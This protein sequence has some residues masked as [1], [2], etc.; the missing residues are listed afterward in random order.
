MSEEKP[1]VK[2]APRKKKEDTPKAAEAPK[3]VSG[4]PATHE[5]KHDA[6]PAEAKAEVKPE[7]KPEPKAA[8]AEAKPK[9]SAKKGK[10][11]PKV[12]LARGKRKTSIARAVVKKGRGVVRVN[13]ADVA[14]HSNKF[15]KYVILEPMSLLGPESNTIDVSVTVEG[16]GA[17]G[18][19]Q[20][21]RTAIAKALVGYF[22]DLNLRTRFLEHDRSLLI[23]DVRRVEP[24]K[25]KG[26]KA[27]ARFQK[28]YR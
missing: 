27:R 26:P 8:V 22:D 12:S 24:K 13:G 18:Q 17:M 2:K 3:A 28:S 1:A 10:A 23:E 16:G 14:A 25:Y 11:G 20:A 7:A 4:T 21:A 9:K 19:A 6:K 15:M 5:H